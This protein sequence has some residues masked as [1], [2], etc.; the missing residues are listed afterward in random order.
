MPLFFHVRDEQWLQPAAVYA[1]AAA[2][3]V[4]G[5]EL[6]GRIASA[7]A[8]SIGVALVFLIAHE[9]T[10]VAW[11][12]AIAALCLMFTPAYWAFAQ[13]G[14]D[15]IIALPLLLL[16]LFN[17]L[18]FL[19]NDSPRALAVA[20]ASLGLA[21]YAHPAAPLTAVFLWILTLAVARRR[22]VTRLIVATAVFGAAW[23]PA[24]AWF[25]GHAQAYPDTFG[26]WFVFAAHL[27]NPV[28]G[29]RAFTNSGTLGNRAS[30]YWGFWDPS[31]LFFR[32]PDAAAP[33]LMIAAPFIALGVLHAVKHI[34]RDVATVLIGA[35]LL[36]PLAGA[37]FGVPHYLADAPLVMPILAVLAALGVAQLVRL[38][39]RRPLEDGVAVHAV[40]GWNDDDALPRA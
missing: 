2:R 12:S 37:T 25:A 4:G 6:S 5:D 7:I 26:R 15:A 21:I 31:W 28:D 23:V 22:V 35:A 1:N 32:A 27:R 13:R 11:V 30:L 18:R 3:S 39:A 8:A 29:L 17:L 20:A 40:D 24:L 33:L 34:S 38:A 9:I 10:A 19:R 14:T 16:W 36:T